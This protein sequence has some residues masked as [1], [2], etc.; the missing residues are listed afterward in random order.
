MACRTLPQR[1]EEEHEAN[2]K[3]CHRS[4]DLDHLEADEEICQRGTDLD[5]L[6]NGTR[7]AKDERQEAD[8]EDQEKLIYAER[9]RSRK[10]ENS[11]LRSRP[12]DRASGYL[13]RNYRTR[14]RKRRNRAR[15]LLAL[16][17]LHNT[18]TEQFRTAGKQ[19]NENRST[20]SCWI[21]LF[22]SDVTAP[23]PIDGLAAIAKCV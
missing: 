9:W 12:D 3:I 16:V 10:V 13:G 2:E 11:C 5:H 15:R 20:K 7:T 4:T 1:N 22:L 19:D 21:A 14:E 6:I 23:H 8:S 17:G 18:S